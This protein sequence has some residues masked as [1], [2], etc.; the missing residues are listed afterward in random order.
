M[1]NRILVI[2]SFALFFLVKLIKNGP[3]VQRF[4]SW[5]LE[6]EKV[7]HGGNGG[8]GRKGH[9]FIYSLHIIP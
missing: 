2:E 6:I 8:D 5:A 7:S 4:A 3:T 1:P 9:N